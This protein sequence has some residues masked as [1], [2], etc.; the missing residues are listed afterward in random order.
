MCSFARRLEIIKQKA[1]RIRIMLFLSIVL[2]ASQQTL[3]PYF[4][5]RLL[6]PGD[7]GRPGTHIYV[8]A[9]ETLRPVEARHTI[10]AVA[11][12][13]P[14]LGQVKHFHLHTYHGNLG[15]RAR[16]APHLLS[17]HGNQKNVCTYIKFS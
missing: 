4:E 14:R 2:P 6:M 16:K 5:T 8:V 11:V 15:I 13:T 10:Y 12:E 17:Y 9:V 1:Y 3:Q 7:P